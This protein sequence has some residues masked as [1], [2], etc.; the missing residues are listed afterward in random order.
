MRLFALLLG[1]GLLCSC[2]SV[3]VRES[4]V[5]PNPGTVISVQVIRSSTGA[6]P[7]DVIATIDR[8]IRQRLDDHGLPAGA[9]ARATWRVIQGEEGS[10]A[11]S[12]ISLGISGSAS[13]TLGVRLTTASGQL[14]QE[15]ETAG[16]DNSMGP[17]YN[18]AGTFAGRAAGDQIARV[19][20]R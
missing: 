3:A 5:I 6:L 13:V 7:A 18:N 8:A 16:S 20:G 14:I 2:G 10:R 1:V 12:A 15:F 11:G 19:L 9:G 17:R 4:G